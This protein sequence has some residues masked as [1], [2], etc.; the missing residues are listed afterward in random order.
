MLR[1]LF[2]AA[3]TLVGML[4]GYGV[5]MLVKLILD[6]PDVREKIKVEFTGVWA[7]VVPII[8]IIVGMLDLAKAVNSKSEDD[9]KKAQQ[10]LVKKAIAAVLVF[11]VVTIVSLLMGLVNSSEYKTCMK[12]VNH[13]FTGDYCTGI[14]AKDDDDKNG[15]D[16]AKKSGRS[17]QERK[18]DQYI[19]SD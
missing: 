16:E 1:R 6:L 18:R 7:I 2:R 5:F 12:C 14:N 19:Q 17:Y 8:L 11:L 10:A 13:P 4:I 9:V 3:F 15:S